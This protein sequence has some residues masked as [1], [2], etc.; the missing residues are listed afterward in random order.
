MHENQINIIF[1]L[2]SP[3]QIG[4]GYLEPNILSMP[5]AR[6]QFQVLNRVTD[7]CLSGGMLCGK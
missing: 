2:I 5:I 6:E 4:I 3:F 7:N 1:Y